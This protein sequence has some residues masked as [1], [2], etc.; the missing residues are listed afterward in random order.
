[1]AIFCRECFMNAGLPDDNL[2]QYIDWAVDSTP[3]KC[4]ACEKEDGTVSRF[5]PDGCLL[6]WDD[7]QLGPRIKSNPHTMY[8]N[9]RKFSMAEDFVSCSNCEHEGLPVRDDENDRH[10]CAK[11]DEEVYSHTAYVPVG[12]LMVDEG[13]LLSRDAG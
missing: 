1:M 3:P 12:C 13:E 6:V 2:N 7:V 4:M 11:C 10:V 5:C 9:T 8:F